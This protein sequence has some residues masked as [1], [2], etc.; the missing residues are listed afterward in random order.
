MVIVSHKFEF[1]L[2]GAKSSSHLHR[3]LRA[4]G[5]QAVLEVLDRRGRYEQEYG[6][7]YQVSY[8]E[9]TLRI[10]LQ[11]DLI[12]S[13]Q[14]VFHWAARSSISVAMDLGPL[15]QAIIRQE[16]VELII[17]HE[18]VLDPVTFT[19]S[20]RPG[21][22]R[23]GDPR[24]RKPREDFSDDRALPR[25]GRSGDDEQPPPVGHIGGRRRF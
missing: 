4:S 23:D 14:T 13:C 21:R 3:R 2:R 8:L 20:R 12:P 15:E 25:P 18:V 22:G 11:D 24:A 19:G 6:L 16:V 17:T 10:D 7:G 1:T 5:T 9:R